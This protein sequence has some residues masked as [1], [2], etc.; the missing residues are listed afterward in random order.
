ME[1]DLICNLLGAGVKCRY[2]VFEPFCMV[3]VLPKYMLSWAKQTYLESCCGDIL[4][5]TLASWSSEQ[6][7][8]SNVSRKLAM[9]YARCDNDSVSY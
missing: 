9:A 1:F 3:V 2:L 8:F 5:S 6:S 4:L 7:Q